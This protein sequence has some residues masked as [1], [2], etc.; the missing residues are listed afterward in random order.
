[1]KMRMQDITGLLSVG[2]V[3]ALAYALL[4]PPEVPAERPDPVAIPSHA[5]ECSGCRLPLFGDA[6]RASHWGPMGVDPAAIKTVMPTS[7][8]T[9]N[10][11]A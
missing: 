4:R 2:A 11:P 9:S 3:A 10:P 6:G 7:R 5:A 8:P 1:M